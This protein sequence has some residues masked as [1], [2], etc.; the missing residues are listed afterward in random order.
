MK[1]TIYALRGRDEHCWYYSHG[2]RCLQSHYG[3]FPDSYCHSEKEA[4]ELLERLRCDLPK[5][6]D[7]FRVVRIDY[8][9]N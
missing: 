3:L 7:G 4:I 8:I 6:S 1:N 2:S 9:M 5:E